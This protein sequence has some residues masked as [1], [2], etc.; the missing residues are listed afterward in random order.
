MLTPYS[1]TLFVDPS[2]NNSTAVI[3]DYTKPWQTINEAVNYAM[4]ASTVSGGY[5]LHV[6]RGNYTATQSVTV[7]QNKSLSIFFEPNANL[8]VNLTTGY[9]MSLSGGT[10]TVNITGSGRSMNYISSNYGLFYITPG[11]QA[12]PS[13]TNLNI[14]N[15][16]LFSTNSANS[17]VAF[18]TGT[19][20][21]A[22]ISTIKIDNSIVSLEP[23]TPLGT[24]QYQRL[25]ELRDSYL[26]TMG[27]TLEFAVR[28]QFEA[29]AT[30]SLG[31]PI[32]ASTAGWLVYE[33]S[34]WVGD[35]IDSARQ[36]MRFQNTYFS[37][38]LTIGG[39]GGVCTYPTSSSNS[40]LVANLY[41][42]NNNNKGFTFY[43]P[44]A[45]FTDTV[46]IGGSIMSGQHSPIYASVTSW[47]G[48]WNLH[49]AQAINM[50]IFDQ[51]SG[52]GT[53]RPY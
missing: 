3:G 10:S 50:G 14:N 9:W 7:S 33:T 8:D 18:G 6:F 22:G 31:G 16:K 26:F 27:S 48:K 29:G 40:I 30:Q 42:H 13:Q 19:V 41:Y 37:N 47:P 43:N 35:S 12:R 28:K 32:G 15:I 52:V 4:T 17:G 36:R 45:A 5:T 51:T 39:G 25:I 38:S 46:W 24:T 11:I 21:L 34:A 20:I 49:P 1:Y 23:S 44:V 2:G 53:N